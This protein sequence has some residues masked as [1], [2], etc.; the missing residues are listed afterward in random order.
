MEFGRSVQDRPIVAHVLGDG[1]D[2][3]AI[4]GALHG[5]EPASAGLA[6]ELL[7]HLRANPTDFEGAMVAVLPEANPDGLAAGTRQNANGV[8]VNR[9]FPTADWAPE[10]GGARYYPGPAPA[11]EPETR[12]LMAFLRLV[13]PRKVIAL[14]QPLEM[15]NPTGTG[16]VLA[17][18]M[19][20][21][22]GYRIDEDTGIPTPGAFG[23]YLM[24]VTLELTDGDTEEAW[25]LQKDA[26]LGAIGYRG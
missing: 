24:M 11:S 15:L 14:H 8:D 16:S 19:A 23:T 13:S 18:V 5:D 7:D 6:W 17:E 4:V 25:A 3:A 10:A 1:P 2:V 22:N 9:N 26:L 20:R 12:A 21:E